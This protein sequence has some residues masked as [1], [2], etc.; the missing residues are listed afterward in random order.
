MSIRDG[1]VTRS[2]LR[3]GSNFP[4]QFHEPIFGSQRLLLRKFLSEHHDRNP[5]ALLLIQMLRTNS[6]NGY[7]PVFSSS[8]SKSFNLPVSQQMLRRIRFCDSLQRSCR[9]TT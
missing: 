3:K 6:K 4:T 2:D 9:R 8:V 5:V 7:S 1:V